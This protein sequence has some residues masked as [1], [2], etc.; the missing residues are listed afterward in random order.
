[1]II[2]LL[3]LSEYGAL[4]GVLRAGGTHHARELLEVELAV[5][6]RVVA[7]TAVLG[8]AQ[9]R[10]SAALSRSRLR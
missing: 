10:G 3:S 9:T 8:A 7:A 2:T 5:A 6:V 4:C 1:M